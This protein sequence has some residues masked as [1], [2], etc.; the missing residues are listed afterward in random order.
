MARIR[1]VKP[2]LFRHEDLYEAEIQTGLPL[3]LSFIGLF[4]ACDREGRFKWKPRQLKL[5]V[6]P[7]DEIDF[8]RVLDALASRGFIIKYRNLR[9]NDDEYGFIPSFTQHQVI[10]N[11]EKDSELPDP[12]E[13]EQYQHIPRDD[14]A[15]TTPLSKEQGEGKGKGKGKEGKG[16]E[17]EG[18]GLPSREARDPDEKPE[19]MILEKLN[20][21][22]G[23]NFKPV[24]P[25]L[26]LIRARLTENHTTKEL[27]DVVAMK[28][29]KWQGGRMDEYLRPSTLFNA[30]KFNQYVGELP[31]WLRERSG[32]S[33]WMDG[34]QDDY[35]DGEVVN[36]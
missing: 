26:K 5:D 2:E 12:E 36:G 32:D 22:T 24:E 17:G 4:T 23:K 33:S 25:N 35:I 7:Y 18:N 31:E 16:K 21:L 11:K 28:V 29:E 20:L 15:S 13:C 3:R 30:E 8:S 27:L 19:I 14:H 1:T 34:L 6:I 10:N 9:D